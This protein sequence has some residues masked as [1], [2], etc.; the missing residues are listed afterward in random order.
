MN[1]LEKN[2]CYSFNSALLKWEFNFKPKKAKTAL[3][4]Y[5]L[6]RNRA[7]PGESKDLVAADWLALPEQERAQFDHLAELDAK[8]RDEEANANMPMSWI[9]LVKT[10][11]RGR[12]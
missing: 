11:K 3:D 9:Q 7:K 2:R 6:K 1:A 4:L 10:A 5:R 12:S 8:R